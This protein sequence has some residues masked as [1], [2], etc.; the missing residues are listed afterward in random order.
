MD[1]Q[2]DKQQRKGSTNMKNASKAKTS[3]PPKASNPAS[4]AATKKGANAPTRHATAKPAGGK[5]T[6]T[7]SPEKLEQVQAVAN[8]G[9][10]NPEILKA[11]VDAII[12]TPEPAKQEKPEARDGSKKA[13]VLA[14]LRRE[15]GATLGEIAKET[16]WQLHSIRGFLSGQIAKKM[17]LKVEST[18]ADGG[19]RRY[20]I[21]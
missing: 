3:K 20:H 1:L 4:K 5:Q 10:T 6:G 16:D 9:V 7:L 12:K 19:K 8:S 11:A 13:V 21:A 17:G 14:M 18:K 15:G 2:G